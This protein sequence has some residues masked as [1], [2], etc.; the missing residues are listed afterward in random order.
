MLVP[1]LGLVQVG[2][3]ARADRY[4]YLPLI[5]LTIAVAWSAA[6]AV[7]GRRVA[8]IAVTGAAVLS[9]ASLGAATAAQVRH[10]RDAVSLHERAVAVTPS[11]TIC[12]QRLALALRR[13]GRGDEAVPVLERAIALSPNHAQPYL[14]LADLR[15]R[16]GELEEAVTLY[17]TGLA[18]EPN[19]A[20]G[21]ANLGLALVRLER[22][23]QARPHLERGLALHDAA[24]G[25]LRPKELAAPHVA[26]ADSLSEAGDLDAAIA[27]YQR[28]RKLDAEQRRAGG[29]L[30]I[31]LAQAGRFQE[32]LPLLR[33]QV[34]NQ[35]YSPKYRAALAMCYANSG[36]TE[37]ALREYRSAIQLRPRWR[38]ATNDLAWIL[39][40]HPDPQVRD[41]EEAVRLIASVLLEPETQ[42][43][44]LDTLAAAYAAV[45]RFD[46]AVQA[47]DRA[48]SR[49]GNQP[50]LAAEIRQRRSLYAAGQPYLAPPTPRDGGPG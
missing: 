22:L 36:F 28:A 37:E 47:A 39:A 43:A 26:L 44:L 45:G 4:S 11:S 27:H 8:R 30:A 6:E 15:A 2:M 12:L 34:K 5:G 1:M 10:W 48:L 35:P 3:Q 42:P 17:E 19:D 41:A 49:A 16:A 33:D 38:H 50:D 23:E 7:Q 13:A 40:T 9:L 18:L 14:A 25:G 29:H 46:E 21:Q 24:G 20:L 32:A 31:A